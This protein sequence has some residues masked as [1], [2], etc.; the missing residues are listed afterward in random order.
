[1]KLL[2]KN[3]TVF[4]NNMAE[5]VSVLV[6]EGRI[7]SISKEMPAVSDARVIEFEQG[8]LCPGFVDVHVHLRE[9]GFS[10]KETMATGTRA[11]ARGGFTSVCP[12]PT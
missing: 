11:A 10:Y 4:Q 8:C 3:V 12:S 7:I 1:M 6:A 2:L 5:K 9:P